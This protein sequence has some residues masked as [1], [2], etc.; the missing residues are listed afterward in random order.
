LLFEDIDGRPL[1]DRCKSIFLTSQ[2]LCEPFARRLVE[3]AAR[4]VVS[5]GNNSLR[6]ALDW[7]GTPQS[8]TYLTPNAEAAA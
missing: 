2:A 1:V 6:A 8:M 5:D 4:E 3:V 7:L